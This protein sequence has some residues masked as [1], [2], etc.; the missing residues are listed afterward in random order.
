MTP[1]SYNQ[2]LILLPVHNRGSL[3]SEFI[4]HIINDLVINIDVHFI[5][6]D[7]G[8]TDQTL[9]MIHR[10]CPRA[11]TITLC[12]NAFWG[13][14]INAAVLFIRRYCD[15]NPD[16]RPLF[17]LC[18]DDIRFLSSY[19]L[20]HA[21]S[22]ISSDTVAC[23]RIVNTLPACLDKVD[24][25]DDQQANIQSPI[26]YERTTG[27]FSASD[28]TSNPPNVSST[29]ALLATSDA[30]LSFGS[31]PPSIPHYL[32]DYW[33]TYNL[34]RSGFNLLFPE[35]FLCVTSSLTTRNSPLR[36]SEN[37]I[38][39]II[40]KLLSSAN[41]CSPSYAPAWIAFYTQHAP[42]V[43]VTKKICK[44]LIRF[45]LGKALLRLGLSTVGSSAHN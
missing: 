14:S 5:I 40:R 16:K 18:N 31:I 30:W 11:H 36:P 29:W 7:D 27:T 32:S 22:M 2:L 37:I 45:W 13:G 42:T 25:S 3:T 6:F 41:P 39:S 20:L 15:A 10:V 38:S 8:C 1:P 9:E 26:H 19:S 28:T 34:H 21:I 33:L 17:M 35:T 24:L 12:G 4:S 43:E 44:H 23:A